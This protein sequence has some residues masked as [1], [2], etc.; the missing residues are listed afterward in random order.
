MDPVKRLK[1]KQLVLSW[2]RFHTAKITDEASS[3]TKA[4]HL[5]EFKKKK[6]RKRKKRRL[7]RGSGC[8]FEPVL[9]HIQAAFKKAFLYAFQVFN[10]NSL[11]RGLNLVC[12]LSL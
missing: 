3:Q 1:F 5:E 9:F 4:I 12:F 7:G 11:S 10:E 2:T 6:G 8:V